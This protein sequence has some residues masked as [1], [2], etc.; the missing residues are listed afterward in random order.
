MIENLEELTDYNAFVRAV[1]AEGGDNTTWS[2]PVKFKTPCNPIPVGTL[3]DFD[4]ETTM[5]QCITIG[6]T[7]GYAANSISLKTNS[8]TI[9]ARNGERAAFISSTYGSSNGSY[10]ALPHI[11]GS[12]DNVQLT[13]WVRPVYHRDGTIS[14]SY[15]SLTT[16]SGA[17]AVTVAAMNDLKD[18]ATYTSIKECIYPYGDEDINRTTKLTETLRAMTGGLNFPCR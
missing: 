13:F 9:V 11:E 1:C 14:F 10:I 8:S 5:P 6:N 17:M 2:E 16:N 4:D 3:Y 12:L 7:E 18:T 15:S